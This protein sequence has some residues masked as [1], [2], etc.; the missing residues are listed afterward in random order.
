VSLAAIRRA[1]EL[2]G[3]AV[4]RNLRAFD[5]GRW[6]M[7]HPEDA[8]RLLEPT[9]IELPKTLAEK[10]AFREEHLTKYQGKALA[11]RYRKLVDMAGRDDLKE[12][13]A[14]GYH[15]LL[16]YKDEYEVARLHLESRAKAEEQFDG[17]FSMTYHL[18]PPI[19]SR[20]GPN[21]RPKKRS[22]GPWMGRGFKILAGLKGLRGTPFD[23]FGYTEERRMERALIAQYEQDMAMVLKEHADDDSGAAV[24]LA[25][26]PRDIRGFG[27]VKAANEAKAAKRREEL[28]AALKA[29][30]VTRAAQ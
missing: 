19:L 22:F 3:A 25:M 7:E 18:A 10:I 6:A 20:M 14:L 11:A 15:K 13:I 16:A 29:G 2:N 21:G 8:A 27:P 1:I 23:V 4:E 26:L 12:A 9:V 24:A 17:D 5:I 28:L 30:P